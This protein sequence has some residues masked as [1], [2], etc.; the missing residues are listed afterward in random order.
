MTTDLS[1]KDWTLFNTGTKK[2]IGGIQMNI[3]GDIHSALIRSNIIP[4]PCYGLN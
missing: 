1:G 2:R 3:P 4:D